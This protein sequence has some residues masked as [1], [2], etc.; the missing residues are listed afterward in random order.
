M[1]TILLIRH[2]EY[3]TIGRYLKGRTAGIGL[4]EKGRAQAESLAGRL[5]ALPMVA[6]Y[7]SPL[8]RALQTAEPIARRQGLVPEVL[9]ALSEIDYGVW[10]GRSVSEMSENPLWRRLHAQRGRSGVPGGEWMIDLAQRMMKA[11]EEIAGRHPDGTAAVV[12]HGDPIRA[13]VCH[14]L[15]IP[16]D[17]IDRLDLR[18]ASVTILELREWGPCLRLYNDTGHLG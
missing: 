14:Y 7:S 17:F 4:N 9:E 2:A 16:L 3:D 11:L 12:S 6:V 1:S 8:E 13:V 10:T 15:G 5:R 18:P